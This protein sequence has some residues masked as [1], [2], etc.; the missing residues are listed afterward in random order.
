M[1]AR[2]H[3][4]GIRREPI[5][6]RR[7]RGAPTQWRPVRALR[8]TDWRALG[9]RM[10][11][12][13]PR[14]GRQGVRRWLPSGRQTYLLFLWTVL[15]LTCTVSIAYQVTDIPKDLNSY[16]TQQD[17]VYYWADGTE[18]A[19]VGP[20]DRQALPLDR[21]APSLA[22]AVLAAENA[23]FYKDHGISPMG[24]GRALYAIGT[25]GDTQGGSTITQQYVKNVYLNQD[26][27][28]SRKLTEMLMAVKL[29]SRM[30]K[31]DIL[32]GYLNTAW[33]GRGAYGVQRAAKAYYGKDASELDVNESAFLATLLKGAGLY[34]P[35]I[36]A[37]NHQRAVKRWNWV[38]DRMVDTG[39]LS[40]A[41]RAKYRT[42]PEPNA[43]A[44]PEGLGGQTGYLVD[45]ARMYVAGHSGI[46]DAEFDLG[47]YQIYTT[48][49]RPK[50]DALAAAVKQHLDGLRPKERAAD[51]DVRVGAA[52][53]ATDGRILALY[54]GSDYIKQG[55]DDADISVVP[56]GTTYGPFVYAA[57][58]R[59][60]VQLKRDAPR[61]PVTPD[62]VYDGDDKIPVRTPEGPYWNRDGKIVKGVN[63]GH[64]SWGKISLRQALARS[65]NTAVMQLGMDVGLDRVRRASIDAGL[66][67]SSFD[68]PQ[69]PGFALGTATPSPIRVADAYGTF[70]AG[71]RHTE[72]Y[73]VRH[74][75]HDG[76]RIDVDRPGPTQP[77]DPKVAAQVDEA[78]RGSI[79]E[80]AGQSVAAV[81]RPLAGKPGT[82]ADGKAA[83][84]AGYD[85]DMATAVA[86]FR[87]DP[88]T[89]QLEPLKG[90]GGKDGKNGS[91]GPADIFTGYMKTVG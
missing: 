86:L 39:K 46:S 48:F 44:R 77:F 10:R 65:V 21:I 22:D 53:V 43:P 85:T 14:P 2:R 26:Q 49:E 34:D 64:R 29:D 41:Q 51:R 57:A 82:S 75:T 59:D 37:A 7:P 74:I 27:T 60:G 23:S 52:C 17:N 55:F 30:S 58:L 76:D 36:S 67:P 20:V 56:V 80:G 73:S 25:G 5:A 33:F 66:L 3:V 63:D 19:R 84:F 28:V 70:A 47:G 71:G 62:S 6:A 90:V 78:L 61:T 88:K 32:D 81:G 9:R 31:K 11:P 45:T 89:Q 83:W 15:G 69:V 72:P 8:T 12:S 35:S 24:I 38:L 1:G 18:M 91:G 68:V 40:R 42:F 87:L 50:V 13:Y 54:G 16:A 79:R 4:K